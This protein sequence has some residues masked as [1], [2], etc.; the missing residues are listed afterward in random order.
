MGLFLI[1]SDYLFA[2]N[3]LTS[4]TITNINF[5]IR[6]FNFCASNCTPYLINHI[7][8]ELFGLCGI[9]VRPYVEFLTNY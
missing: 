8:K 7:F 6:I 1:Y 2:E 5:R 9:A 4:T 3:T